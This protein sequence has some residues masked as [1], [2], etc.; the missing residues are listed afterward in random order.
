MNFWL[1]AIVLLISSTVFAQTEKDS[2]NLPSKLLPKI[3]DELL[4]KDHLTFVVSKQDSILR[5]YEHKDSIHQV[6]VA[7]YK[8]DAVE[9]KQVITKLEKKNK[10][11]EDE[12][13]IVYKDKKKLTF[14]NKMLKVVATIETIAIVVGVVIL[15]II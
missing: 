11:Y 14:Q 6:E 13:Q 9:Y 2:T 10:L 5:V 7:Q 3:I 8:L 1:T 4:V 15:I 12:L